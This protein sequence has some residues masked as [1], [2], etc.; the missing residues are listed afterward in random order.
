MR[1][2]FAVVC[3]AAS[4]C[5]S[6]LAEAQAV[7]DS[8]KLTAPRKQLLPPVVVTGTLAPYSQIKLGIARSVVTQAQLRAEPARA[9]VDPLRRTTGVYIDEAT[10]PLGPTIIRLRGGE[11]TFTQVL[12]DGVSINENGGFFD[13]QGVALVNVDRIEVGRGPQSAVYGSSA[14]SGVVQMFTRAAEAGPLRTEGLVETGRA[15]R[16]DETL[17]A[18]VETSV[19][20]NARRLSLGVGSSYDRGPFQL[21]HHLRAQDASLRADLLPTN[22]LV[23]TAIARYMNV[24]AMLPVRDPGVT[25]APLDP[26]QRQ[27]RERILGSLQTEWAP[28][29]W[30][31]HRLLL[32]YYQRDFTYEDQK[33]GLDQSQFSSYVFDADYH[34]R[35]IV[36]RATA[37]YVGSATPQS[38]G[39]LGFALSYGGEWER[40]SLRDKQSG[41]F[42]PASQ[43]IA[44]PR[45]AAFGE[46]QARIGS[47]LSLLL[48]SRAE[49]F[50]GVAPVYVPRAT[51]VLDLL[52]DRVSLRAAVSRA[53]KA[54]N[55]QDQF[56]SSP[57]I[58]AN[59]DLKPETSRSWEAGV[60]VSA[61]TWQSS[62]SVTYFHQ[63]FENLIRS[64]NF[65][66]TRQINRNLGRS[67]ATGLEVEIVAQPADRWPV[68]ASA[69]WISTTIL[70][71]GGL[72]ASEFP[73]GE[74]LPFRPTYTASA[75]VGAPVTRRVSVLARVLAVGPQTV[76]V[77]RF[78]GPRASLDSYAVLSATATWVH[79][80]S[81]DMFLRAENILNSAYETAYDRP[82]IHRFTA[83]GVRVRG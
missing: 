15:S 72:P 42:G 79:S 39:A 17:R 13:A 66:G 53:Y 61:S 14:M 69:A 45:W 24:D 54:P 30:W 35:A 34:Y 48:G 62:A 65:D 75:Y 18:I 21:P 56:P 83:V 9:A 29:D 81:L 6:R 70:D 37:R 1:L 51:A 67:R 40:E 26:T 7:A 3:L 73:N 76:L 5:D 80:P 58:V 33:E 46:G 38:S 20:S 63:D 55:I 74:S 60:D 59:P 10:G 49:K 11:E 82:G 32:S 52:P 43:S 64:V 28:I 57:A 27:A 25:R 36:E 41:E 78:S 50:R 44:R 19:G 71:N 22:A 23:L 47:R 2:V 16:F 31:S 12:M 68:G 77:N 4:I 8:S